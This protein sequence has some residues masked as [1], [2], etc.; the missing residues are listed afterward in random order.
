MPAQHPHRVNLIERQRDQSESAAVT[1]ARAQ[2]RPG[3]ICSSM[4]P[5]PVFASELDDKEGW[6]PPLPKSGDAAVSGSGCDVLKAS[7]RRLGS[8]GGQAPL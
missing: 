3:P 6:Q 2:Q 8:A 7:G 5:A 1:S 4:A